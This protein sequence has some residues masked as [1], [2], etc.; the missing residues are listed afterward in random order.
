M[1]TIEVS[2]RGRRRLGGKGQTDLG[3]LQEER[4]ELRNVGN[5]RHQCLLGFGGGG[6]DGEGRWKKDGGR[7]SSVCGS[8]GVWGGGG[9]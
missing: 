3:E 1:P 2:R 8:A 9:Y 7:G 4:G 5:N 6:G